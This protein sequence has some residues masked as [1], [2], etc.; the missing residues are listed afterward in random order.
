MNFDFSNPEFLWFLLVPLALIFLR[1]R[2]GKTGTLIFSSVAIAKVAARKNKSGISGILF[3]LRLLVIS[4]LI[5]GLARP[6]LGRGFSEREESGI[7]IVLAVDVSGSM[8]A[9]DLSKSRSELLTRLDAVKS[10][11]ETFIKNRPNDRIGMI[12]FGSNPFLVSPLTLNHDWLLQNIERVEIGSID[13]NSTAIGSAIA[14]SVNR[15]RDLKD[16]KSRV[17]ILLT[18]GDNNAGKISPI[19]AAEAAAGFDTK[20]YTIAA[21]RPGIVPFASMDRSGR[22]IRTRNGTPVI[23]GNAQSQIDESALKKIAELT[24]GQFYRATDYSDLKSIY[25]R[26]DALE[27]TNVKI[28]NFT[29]YKE[30][31][32]YPVWLAF[33]LLMLERILSHTRFRRLP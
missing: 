32:E 24:G 33:A 13:G 26:I 21:G 5:I 28:K 23:G 10:V 7:D 2:I 16:A 11:I 27:K 19:A 4:L 25:N 6:R 20:I 12:I 22:I 3:A 18:D 17:I 8:S 31:F 14:M 15:L 29:E 1:G 30:L 9:L